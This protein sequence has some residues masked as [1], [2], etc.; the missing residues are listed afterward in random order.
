MDAIAAINERDLDVSRGVEDRISVTVRIDHETYGQGWKNE[1]FYT[2]E[3][4][5]K[6]IVSEE[7]VTWEVNTREELLKL[8]EKL[9]QNARVWVSASNTINLKDFNS[10]KIEA[11][12]AMDVEVGDG[13]DFVEAAKESFSK[14][15]E[16]VTTEVRS[17]RDSILKRV[18]GGQE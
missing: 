16:L 6:V 5:K 8:V 18:F 9:S 3:N 13:E 15:W 7:T 11:G 12:T 4:R 14:A 2:V 17:M 10:A 1:T